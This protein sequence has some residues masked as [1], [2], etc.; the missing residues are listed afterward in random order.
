MAIGDSAGKQ[1]IDELTTVTVP[2][3]AKDLT[4]LLAPFVAF[5]PCIEAVLQ[6]KKRLVI[7]LEDVPK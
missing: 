1:A 2:L 5:L 3:A 7:T 6:G 4:D